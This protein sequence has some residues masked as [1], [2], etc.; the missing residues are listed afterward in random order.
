MTILTKENR[1]NARVIRSINNPENGEKQFRYEEC[2]DGR[3]GVIILRSEFY[4]MHENGFNVVDHGFM[5]EDTYH[6]WEVVA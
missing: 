2:D 6:L 1:K 3:G 4:E 5:Y